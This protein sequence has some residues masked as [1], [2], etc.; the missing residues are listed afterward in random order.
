MFFVTMLLNEVVSWVRAQ[1]GSRSLRAILYMDEIFGYFPPSATPP[2]KRPMLTLLKQARAQGLG[3]VLAT[4]NPVDLDYKG[5]SNTGTWFIGRLQTEQDRNRVMDGLA[6]ASDGALDRKTTERLIAGLSSRVFLMQNAHEDAPVL[7]RTRWTLSYLGG[8]LTG[9]QITRLVDH[10]EVRVPETDVATGSVATPGAALP[11]ESTRPTVPG[12]IAERFVVVA[13]PPTGEERLVYRPALAAAVTLHYAN[14]RA[15]V[16]EWQDI[17]LLA[18]LLGVGRTSP[19]K[20]AVETTAS[21]VFEDDPDPDATFASLPSAASNAKS[22][23]TWAKRL[24]GHL[25][26]TRPLR[27]WRCRKPKLTGQVGETEGDFKVRL[28]E[29]LR[30]ERDL[31]VEKLRRRYAPKLARMEERI[32]SAEQRVDV[33]RSQYSQKKSQ[34]AISLGATVVGALFGRKLGSLGN[35]GRATTTMRGAGRAVRERGDIA[36][37][38]ERVSGLRQQLADL[39]AQF[40]TDLARLHSGGNLEGVHIKALNLTCRK[41][42]IDIAPLALVWTPWRVGPQGIAEPAYDA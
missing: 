7:F 12:D 19:W 14:V 27:L 15:N 35:L 13:H 2:S 39:E 6:G 21:L 8:P 23:A 40:E 18:P 5:L 33:E 10:Q 30:A 4:Q 38:K 17:H 11:S 9:A 3:V 26:R 34:A 1:S 36:R 32:R 42:D 29:A 22:Y 16:D 20:T 28:R 25:Y 31:A 24:P 37:A 41:T